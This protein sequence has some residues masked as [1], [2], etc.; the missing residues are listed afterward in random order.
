MIKQLKI[1]EY[2]STKKLYGGS[3]Y[4][5]LITFFDRWFFFYLLKI[6]LLKF[7]WFYLNFYKLIAFKLII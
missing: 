4:M 1:C 2:F 6:L 7:L 5:D 3:D